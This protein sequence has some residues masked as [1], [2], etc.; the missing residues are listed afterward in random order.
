MSWTRK[1]AVPRCADTL[2][3]NTGPLI[4][5]AKLE[6]L[7][8][9]ARLFARVLVPDIVWRELT[10]SRGMPEIRE[11]NPKRLDLEIVASPA[12]DPLLVLQLDAGEASVLRVARKFPGST[13]LIDE[14]KARQVAS[15]VYGLPVLGTGGLLLRAKRAGLI[16]L[17]RPV[18]K[19]LQSHG[20]YIS[21]KIVD[22]ICIE[23][24]EMTVHS[25]RQPH[26]APP[27]LLFVT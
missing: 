19:N 21:D 24:G 4:A 25:P 26:R 5:L 7:E 11:V 10:R 17:V 15:I 18:L 16:P 2:V 14:R 22:R 1:S 6:C 13:V 12:A 9:L 20:Y 27:R 8:L 23:A 3:C